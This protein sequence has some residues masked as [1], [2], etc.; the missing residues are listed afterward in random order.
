M[1]QHAT[2]IFLIKASVRPVLPCRRLGFWRAGAFRR[3]SV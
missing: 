1:Y 2:K 3:R